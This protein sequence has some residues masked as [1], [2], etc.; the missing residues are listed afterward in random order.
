[1]E[2]A[3]ND[4]SLHGQFENLTGFRAAID[5]VMEIRSAARRFGR[6]LYCGHGVR[7]AQ[8]TSEHTMQAA[9]ASCPREQQRVIAT[10]VSKQGPFWEEAR[11]HDPAENL[12][13]GEEPVTDTSVGEAAICQTNGIDRRLVS[14]A[15]SAW[16]RDPLLVQR[17][18]DTDTSEISIPNYWELTRVQAALEQAPTPLRSWED[19]RQAVVTR[20]P[21]LTLTEEAF[22][23]MGPQPFKL[24][25]AERILL[26]LGILNRMKECFNASGQRTP[27]GDDMAQK[28]FVGERARFSDSSQR[29]K[30]EMGEAL[31]FPDPERPGKKRSFPWHGK[32]QTP[33]YRIHFSY[34]ITATDPLYVVYVGLKLTR[35]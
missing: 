9:V 21:L 1:M 22:D 32:V 35:G 20:F 8:I 7:S 11:T 17:H 13:V 18:G 24:G 27:E 28:W 25:P 12:F 33:P 10:W 34:P 15:P 4:L 3:V 26:L 5:Q 16:C 14:F 19:V 31:E 30:N 2:L 29:E 6:E 23:T